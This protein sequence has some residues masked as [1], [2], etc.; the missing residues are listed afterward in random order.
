M[1]K[2][3]IEYSP[4]HP[5]PSALPPSAPHAQRVP[6]IFAPLLEVRTAEELTARTTVAMSRLGFD[7][8]T[9]GAALRLREEW[10]PWYASWTTMPMAWV[11]RYHEMNYVETDPRIHAGFGMTIPLLWDR[12][13]LGGTSQAERFFDD[14][15]RFGV[16]SG[17]VFHFHGGAAEHC[18]TAFNSSRPTRDWIDD[19]AVGQAYLFASSFHCWFHDALVGG[20]FA[21]A[22]RGLPPTARE[23]ECLSLLARG[24]TNA[25]IARAMGITE[26]TAGYYVSKLLAKLEA[27][28]R[29]EAV[30]R[31]LRDRLVG[32]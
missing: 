7:S 16:S 5:L 17:V 29:T 20:R 24:F 21:P 3:P 9:Y 11:V 13:S 2:R 10:E 14:A 32:R 31:A 30:A 23:R 22:T 6:E 25:E 15:A 4:L 26:R 28:N 8:F 18:M 1:A 12:V 19:D 27:G